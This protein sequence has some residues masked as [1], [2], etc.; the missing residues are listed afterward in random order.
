MKRLALVLA[1]VCL[2]VPA[3][4]QDLAPKAARPAHP[5]AILGA[6]VHPVSGPAIENGFVVIVDGRIHRVGEGEVELPP[7]VRRIDGAGLHV[8]PGLVGTWTNLGLTEIGAVRATRDFEETG[9]V[10]P[11]VLALTAVNP[12]STLIPVAR[13]NGILT[14][15]TFPRGPGIAGRGSVIRMDGWTNDDLA[16]RR[17]AGLVVAWPAARPIR[18][19]WME[20][21]EE[22]Q[23]REARESRARIRGAFAK[24]KAY[25][26][27]RATDPTLPV[28][29]RWEAMR[30]VLPGKG[31]RR[32]FI[33]ANDYDQIVGAVRFA[34]KEGLRPVIVGGRDARLCLA[35]LKEHDVPVVVTGVWR[36]PKRRDSAVTESYDLP[37]ALEEAGI[38]W[39]LASGQGASNE[40]NLPYAAAA[41]V[42][43]G[44]PRAAA[45]RAITLSAAEIL[46]VGDQL[47][48]LESGK[49][50]TLMVTTG[51]PLEMT[52]KIRRA[53]IDGREV[54]LSN[55][56]TRLAEKYREKY[57]QRGLLK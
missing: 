49:R 23:K 42:R 43:H 3:V 27:A 7:K 10:R 14:V 6:T 4:A 38:R 47:G 9:L 17:D 8:W 28:D 46:G 55:K 12:D 36:L 18:A 51:D 57:R 54:D 32:V 33:A 29:V 44:L 25:R 21:S 56:Q 45:H 13:S 35:L 15:G 20:K 41:A 24:A 52:T 30:S 5:I 16:V 22:E 48:S 37:A 50:A 31:Q 53:F 1:L 34:V 19:W 40:R 2:V 39:C 11:E 26:K